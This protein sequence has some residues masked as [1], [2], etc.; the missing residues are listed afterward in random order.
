MELIVFG[1][2]GGTG[3]QVVEQA[4]G[5]GHMVTAVARR[6]SAI[7]LQHERLEVVQGDVF[8]PSTFEGAL[9][10][11]DAVI[12]AM[13][14]NLRTPSTVYS[15]GS[16][17]IMRAMRAAGVH[18]LIAVSAG[19]L[20]PGPLWQ[21]LIARPLLWLLFK[22][23]Y[24][25]MARMEVEIKESGLDWTIIRPPKLTDEPRSGGYQVAVNQHLSQGWKLSR[26]DLAD[27]IVKH[28]DDPVTYCGL[29]EIAY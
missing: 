12:A 17:N 19:G 10:A 28:L 26:A 9:A 27:Y 2:T 29:V 7:T 14:V 24:T 4:L 20:D 8:E 11:K 25:D 16:A 5:A 3:G 23:G 22:N 1:A 18:R 6:P 13:G 15:E 21:R